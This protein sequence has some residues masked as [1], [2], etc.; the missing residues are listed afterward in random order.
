LRTSVETP[1]KVS[2]RPSKAVDFSKIDA[3]SDLPFGARLSP[4]EKYW[5]SAFPKTD[6]ADYPV[7]VVPARNL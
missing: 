3:Q 5:H 7:F 1:K 2:R 6:D 4:V